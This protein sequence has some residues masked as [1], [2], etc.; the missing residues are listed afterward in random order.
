MSGGA[1]L[2]PTILMDRPV[3]ARPQVGSLEPHPRLH[4]SRLPLLQ[5]RT[6]VHC[7]SHTMFLLEDM[8]GGWYTCGTCGAYA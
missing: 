2:S 5:A 8:R 1:E 3:H 6:C 7:G 4:G